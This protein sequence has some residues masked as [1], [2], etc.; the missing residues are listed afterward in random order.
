MNDTKKHLLKLKLRIYIMLTVIYLIVGSISVTVFHYLIPERYFGL[1]PALGV[2]YWL[3]GMVLNFLLDRCRSK[4]LNH[5]M[6]TFMMHK[7]VKFSLTV[8]I[9]FIYVFTYPENKMQF[10]ITL[11]AYYLTFSFVELYIYFIY[12]KKMTKHH[13]QKI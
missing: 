10:G 9:L 13:D 8:L 4:H 11:M 2:F 6:N 1:Y 7:V 5:C 12:N 3:S